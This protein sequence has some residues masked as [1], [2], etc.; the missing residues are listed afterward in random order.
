MEGDP[1]AVPEVYGNLYLRLIY[2]YPHDPETAAR[3]VR[4]A[5]P[6]STAQQ[7]AAAVPDH[8]WHRLHS[9]RELGRRIEEGSSVQPT[10]VAPLDRLLGGG[11]RRGQLVEIVGR[12]GSGRFSL[13]LAA[14]AAA[15]RC[16]ETAALIDLG[17]ALDPQNATALGVD[18]HR[19]LWARPRHLK[20]ALHATESLAG[21]GFPLI[22][23]DLGIPPVP[24][25]R[26][27]EAAWLR[28]ARTV[29]KR[30]IV[31]MVTTPYRVSGTAAGA[32]LHTRKD[33]SRWSGRSANP[34]LLEGSSSRIGL[35]KARR[36]S[37]DV[38]ER[39]GLEAFAVTTSLQCD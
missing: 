34:R 16:G 5:L 24:G 11:F 2:A 33:R 23:L 26:G 31:L 10:G 38:R 14:L 19:L 18:L 1:D 8:L 22:V 7:L 32:V 30:Q 28:L 35:A 36:H 20:Q 6:T 3:H 9:A 39:H 21:A 37:G 25:G 12:P 4:M 17:D 29:G 15:T 13:A 27:V